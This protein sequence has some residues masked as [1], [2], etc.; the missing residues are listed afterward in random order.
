[1]LEDLKEPVEQLKKDIDDVWSRLN[2]EEIRAKIAEKEALTTAEG[3]WDDNDKATKVMND[4]KMLK[5]RIEPWEELRKASDDMLTLYELGMEEGDQGLES[6]LK[7]MYEKAKAE[8]EA[9]AVSKISESGADGNIGAYMWMLP[10]MY[11]KRWQTTQRIEAEVDNTQRIELV[12][13]SDKQ[14]KDED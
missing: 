8:F 5:G 9:G 6:E 12:R 4:I 1:M 13:F 7:E 11:P 3:F 14:K 2:P 10:R